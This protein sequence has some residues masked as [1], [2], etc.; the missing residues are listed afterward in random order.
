[1][2]LVAAWIEPQDTTMSEIIE[3]QTTKFCMFSI[4]CGNMNFDFIEIEQKT[5]YLSLVGQREREIDK[6]Q[7]IGTKTS[8]QKNKF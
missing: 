1:M 6:N 2:L 8:L 7:I 3:I 5:G 4:T